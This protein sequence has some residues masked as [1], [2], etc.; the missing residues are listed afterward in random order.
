MA[1]KT[2]GMM[3]DAGTAKLVRPGTAPPDGWTQLDDRIGTVMS[4]DAD[5]NLSIRGHYY[6]PAPAAKV[7]NAYVSKGLAGR[8]AIF[9]TLQAANNRLNALQLG[10]SAFHATTT[11]VN[12]AASDIAL[13]VQQLTQGKPLQAIKNVAE[14]VTYIPSMISTFRNGSKLMKEYLSP[15][16]YAKFAREANAIS[17]AGGRIKQNTIEIKPLT[18]A[19]DDLKAGAIGSAM[20]KTLPALIDAS[21]RPIMEGWVPRM[22]LGAFYGMANNILDTADRE[23]WSQDQVRTRMQ[24]AWDS[25]DNRFGQMVYDN[26]FWN[27]ALRDVLMASTRSVGWNAGTIRELGGA[28]VDTAQQAGKVVSGKAPE[29]TD[30]MGFAIGMT[31]SA[32]LLGSAIYYLL[33]GERPQT[34]KDAYFPGKKGEA[35][36]SIPGY[37]KDV[38][39]YAH[40]PKQT[41]LNKMSPVLSMLSAVLENRDFYGTEIRHPDDPVVQQLWQLAKFAGAEAMPFSVRGV[42]KLVQQKGSL[43]ESLPGQVKAAFRNPK[44]LIAGQ[45]GFQPAPAYI[46]NSPALN[47]A[48]EYDMANM[49]PGTRTQ[50]QAEKQRLR[51]AIAI[52][53]RS[54]HP[55]HAAIANLVREGKLTQKEVNS[56]IT[57]AKTNPLVRA[58]RPLHLDQLLN[59]YADADQKE[60]PL[61]R[62][63]IAKKTGDVQKEMDPQRRAALRAALQSVL[64]KGAAGQNSGTRRGVAM[65]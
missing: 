44:E 25:I 42:Q 64:R 43:E 34:W 30:R 26:L 53:Y 50:E 48:H 13:G 11:A 41:L 27:K 56:A 40:D 3:K 6:A 21:A 65:P 49:P 15:G 62:P 52:Q 37:M 51:N 60:R 63:I 22:K 47:K 36:M 9:D 31:V 61:L 33:N 18:Q 45:F 54:G 12:A 1:H 2:L 46:Q 23:H 17:L 10:I 20:K 7:F 8:S 5:G 35:R 58:A 4:A 19:L 29:L 24:T 16:S 38:V 32:G 14:G 57:T 28:A 55:D 39:A 59:V